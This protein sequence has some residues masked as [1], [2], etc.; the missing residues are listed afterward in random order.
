MSR[1]SYDMSTHLLREIL[2]DATIKIPEH[3]RPEMW[4]P[5]RQARLIETI[6]AGRPM[7]P[8]IFRDTINEGA[9]VRWLED[10]QQRY[11]SMKK[12]HEN[13]I[14]LNGKFYRDFDEN[15]RIIFQTYKLFVLRYE[16][17]T[18]QETIDIFDT[19]Q[20]GVPLSPGQRF[21]ARLETPLVKY[22]RERLLTPGMHFYERATRVWGAHRATDDT[23]TKKALMNA[24]AIAGGLAHGIEY[25]TTSYD[26]LGP[27]LLKGF[28]EN[29]AD[30]VL[31]NLLAVYEAAEE[32]HALTVPDK[33]KQWDVGKISGYVL[34]SFLQY[35]DMIAELSARWTNYLVDVRQGRDMLAILHHGCP[36]S[37]NWNSGRWSI[38]Y[39]HHHLALETNARLQI[40]GIHETTILLL[41]LL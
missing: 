36:K 41:N 30:V 16:N 18:Q 19:F 31:G 1:L 24:M 25:I 5:P 12:F 32:R 20:N 6:M 14:A 23:K 40:S 34:Y 21:H 35:P 26:I 33:K 22:A 28:D 4:K 37:R 7:P 11:I 8:L 29:Q 3:Q 17:A 13:R 15:Q 39:T 9:R 27:E 38:G 2:A 10:G